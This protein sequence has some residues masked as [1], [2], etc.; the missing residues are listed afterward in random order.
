[1]VE[2]GEAI[3]WPVELP[4]DARS[5]RG[6]GSGWSPPPGLS[7]WSAL[8]VFGLVEATR[9]A[10]CRR[11]YEAARSRLGAP[12]LAFAGSPPDGRTLGERADPPSPLQLHRSFQ[13][14]RTST[15]PVRIHIARVSPSAVSGVTGHFAP[16]GA[17]TAPPRRARACPARACSPCG[18]GTPGS[19]ATGGGT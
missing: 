2:V 8:A 9:N 13:A 14:S 19:A 12:A 18:R 3:P 16:S 10:G 5:R 6:A 1:M 15:S 17:V 7:A 11:P 4:R